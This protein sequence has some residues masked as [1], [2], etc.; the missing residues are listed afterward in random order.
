MKVVARIID[1][2]PKKDRRF[3]NILANSGKV[4]ESGEI[5]SLDDMY[6]MGYD[7]KLYKISDLEKNPDEQTVEYS[8]KAQADHGSVELD[9]DSY[10][11]FPTI[12][13]QFGSC[14]VWLEEDGLHARIFRR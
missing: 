6:V 9:G 7:A 13:K 8:V 10:G 5:R 11:V 4:M 2:K 14:K 3:R 1:S 12:E